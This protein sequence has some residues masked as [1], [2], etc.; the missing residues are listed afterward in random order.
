MKKKFIDATHAEISVCIEQPRIDCTILEKQETP[1]PK[2][3]GSPC[4]REVEK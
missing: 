3:T 1:C 4:T 2:P